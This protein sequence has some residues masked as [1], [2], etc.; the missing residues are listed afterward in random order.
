M[1]TICILDVEVID[2]AVLGHATPTLIYK[3]V[4]IG[5]PELRRQIGAFAAS[6]KQ[7]GVKRGDRLAVWLPNCPAWLVAHLG[8]ARIGAMTM[9]VNTRF[10]SAE[11]EDILA[12]SGARLL[13]YWPG[14]LDIDF[15]AVLAQVHPSALERL[16]HLVAYTEDAAG[17]LA[18]RLF[19]VPQHDYH[20]L[21]ADDVGELADAGRKGDGAILF[22]TSGTT[23]KPKL[24]LHTQASITSHADEVAPAFGY[25][26]ADTA[27]LQALPLCGTFGHAQA[28]SVLRASGKLVLMPAFA[29]EPA[30]DLIQE[31]RVTALNGAD[32]MFEDMMVSS[33]AGALASVRGGGFAAFATPDVEDFV[34]RAATFDLE[35]FGLYGMSEVQALFARQKPGAAITERAPGGGFLVSPRAHFRVCDPDSCQVLPPGEAGELQLQGPSLF[36]EYFENPE[37][38]ARAMTAD[39]YLRTGDLARDEGGGR[40]TYLARMG[41]SLRL[42]G[43]LTSPAE[44]EAVIEQHTCVGTAQVVGVDT[45]RGT[46][47]FAFV[48]VHHTAAPDADELAQLCRQRLAKYKVP[49]RFVTLDALPMTDSPNGQKIQRVRLREM[50]MAHVAAQG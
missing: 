4:R 35:L 1:L 50:A 13:L 21:V 29:L 26:A 24:A 19:G 5:T 34:A 48:T 16:E 3:G 25:D 18:T 33:K 12:R 42:G 11:V 30:L 36:R 10:R 38:T 27:L 45:A 14:F 40:F 39:G 49:I 6:L 15:D 37:A 46:R 8:A 7:L 22:T 17:P 2:N 20:R 44:I 31:H 32:T 43:F 41:D 9:A 47:P 28:M 23:G